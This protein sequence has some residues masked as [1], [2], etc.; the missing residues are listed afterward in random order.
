MVNGRVR[1]M[2]LDKAIAILKKL[3]IDATELEHEPFGSPKRDEWTDTAEGALQRVFPKDGSILKNFGRAQSIV[4]KARDSEENLR[5]AANQ[6][7][8][9]EVGVLRS[10]IKQLEWQVPAG[11]GKRQSQTENRDREGAHMRPTAEVLNI[12]IASPSDVNEERNVVERVI[13]DW[14]ASH[15]S[16]MGIMLNPI[17][18][19]SHTYPAS[20][21]RPQAII[22]RQMVESGDILI[23]I[24]GYKLGTPTGAAQS[25]TIEEIEG[26]RR[27]GKYVALYFSTANVPRSADRGQ[28]EALESYKRERQKDTLYFEF[29]DAP[30]LRNHLTRHLPKV[31]YAVREKLNLRTPQLGVDFEPRRPANSVDAPD[32]YPAVHEKAPLAEIDRRVLETLGDRTLWTGARPMTGAGEPA[33]RSSEIAQ[34]LSLDTEIIADSL[35]RLESKGRAKN[36]G[37]TLD[38]PAPYWFIIRR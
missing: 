23:A 19:E 17:R 11:E 20:G 18:W 5:K 31:V 35:G 37:G 10:A 38:N 2:P 22:N 26:F 8:S 27:A 7:L 1:E 12:L 9:S 36:A 4:F 30:G 24:F 6:T 15:F 3:V 33:V 16:T 34:L 14:N 32:E 29:E 13:H 28:L 25:G 21:D